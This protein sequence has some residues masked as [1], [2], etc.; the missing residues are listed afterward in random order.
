MKTS[1]SII[2]INYNSL[3]DTINF[4]DTLSM[5][6]NFSNLDLEVVVVDNASDQCPKSALE[7]YP[8]VKLVQS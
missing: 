8:W 1:V 7:D 3:E 5:S 6:L 2:T 4:L